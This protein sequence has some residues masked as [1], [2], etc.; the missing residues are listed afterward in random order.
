MYTYLFTVIVNYTEMVFHFNHLLNK[1]ND[2]EWI[3][4]ESIIIYYHANVGL[5]LFWRK[6]SDQSMRNNFTDR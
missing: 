4:L 2:L 1:A 5:L 6:A 3:I